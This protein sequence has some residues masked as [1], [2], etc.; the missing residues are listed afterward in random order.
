MSMTEQD[1]ANHRLYESLS[2]LEREAIDR[3]YTACRHKLVWTLEKNWTP[4]NCDE[5]EALIA[6]IARYVVQS[7]RTAK[8]G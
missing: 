2:E 5:A 3:A 1:S 8:G 7:R 6:A 4:D